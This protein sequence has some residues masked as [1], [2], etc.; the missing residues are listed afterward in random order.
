MLKD[1]MSEYGAK[2]IKRLINN[3]DIQKG[4]LRYI[5]SSVS[6]DV[7]NDMMIKD[8]DSD[9]WWG[10]SASGNKKINDHQE[11]IAL[12]SETKGTHTEHI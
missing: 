9:A 2:F 3:E 7:R 10:D 1:I 8:P 4:F 5:W 12:L 6:P 11:I